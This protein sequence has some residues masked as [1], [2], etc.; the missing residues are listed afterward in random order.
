[1]HRFINPLSLPDYLNGPPPN[2]SKAENLKAVNKYSEIMSQL[3]VLYEQCPGYHL[4]VS[5][6]SLG[7]SLAQLF[8]MEAAASN[9]KFIPKPVTTIK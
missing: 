1:L 6:H 7:A 2:R 5:G 4:Y 8:A 9:D 3:S